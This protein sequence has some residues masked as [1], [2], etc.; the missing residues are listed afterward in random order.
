MRAEI[1]DLIREEWLRARNSGELVWKSA[2]GS[3]V[4]VKDMTDTHLRN[5]IK[6]MTRMRELSDMK[7]EWDARWP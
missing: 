5:A 4:A 6:M 2:D 7:A 1:D 3:E